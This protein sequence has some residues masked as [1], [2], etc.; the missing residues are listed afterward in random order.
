MLSWEIR[1]NE[2]MVTPV[3]AISISYIQ[4]QVIIIITE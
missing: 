2:A 4:L 3:N 1:T